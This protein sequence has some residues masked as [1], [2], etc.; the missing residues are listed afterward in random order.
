MASLSILPL[1]SLW[2]TAGLVLGYV[3]MMRMS[4]FRQ[5]YLAILG[6]L[7]VSPLSQYPSYLLIPGIL[8]IV[9]GI[10]SI[11]GIPESPVKLPTYQVSPVAPSFR[12]PRSP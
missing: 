11:P 7:S 12:Y 3:L 1:R 8:G 6:I 9:A 2:F 5:F 4:G 10:P